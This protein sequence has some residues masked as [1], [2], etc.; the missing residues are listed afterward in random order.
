MKKL[1]LSWTL[2]AVLALCS[3]LAHSDD[4]PS[5]PPC[6][7]G[8]PGRGGTVTEHSRQPGATFIVHLTDFNYQDIP[9]QDRFPQSIPDGMGGTTIVPLVIP[10][11]DGLCEARNETILSQQLGGGGGGAGG[12]KS[13]L[14]I[15]S[16]YFNLV[17]NRY[18]LLNIWGTIAQ[19]LGETAVVAIPDLYIAD[20]NGILNGVTL[21][22]L[23]DL[24]VYVQAIPT[25]AEGDVFNV[26]N[27]V[28][29]GLPGMRFS[30]TPFTF[31]PVTG[32]TDP[33]YT[34]MA[35]AETQ[36]GFTPAVPEPSS[37]ALLAAGMAAIVGTSRRWK[38]T[39]L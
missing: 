36:H 34:G 28:V 24:A 9:G 39:P 21:Y 29:A 15:E 25:F 7:P 6:V 32:F 37:V 10:A 19:Q 33:P 12:P 23:V 17:T 20:A 38:K 14:S 8:Q 30:T 16:I 35:I 27:G 13:D 26:V 5:G 2:A 18:E 3:G 4:A 1:R 22:S 11:M 31:D